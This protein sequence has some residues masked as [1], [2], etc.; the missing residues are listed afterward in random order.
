MRQFVMHRLNPKL[1]VLPY[2]II[3]L[4][5]VVGPFLDVD[6]LKGSPEEFVFWAVVFNFPHI[7]SSFIVTIDKDYV[8]QV[9]VKSFGPVLFII[10]SSMVLYIGSLQSEFRV[11]F[12]YLIVG[13][14][15]IFTT[16]HVLSQQFGIS[17]LILKQRPVFFNVI[18][19]ISL[20]ASIL[21]Y[22]K[23]FLSKEYTIVVYFDYFLIGIFF[24]LLAFLAVD[25][26]KY[27]NRIGRFHYCLNIVMML[28]LIVFS[29]FEWVL[30]L[31]VVP[32]FVHD[33]SAFLIYI[34]HDQNKNQRIVTNYV[35]SI[36]PAKKVSFWV[37]TPLIGILVANFLEMIFLNYLLL[38]F[39]ICDFSHYYLESRMWKKGS[40]FRRN[41]LIG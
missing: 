31:L 24:L 41:V 11:V 21:L 39:M 12:G 20:I 15:A 9:K 17:C 40:V 30:A 4:F 7:V 33:I 23:L 8:G 2:I 36:L 37:I 35:Y 38:L 22:V 28:V 14:Y 10:A 27:N 34:N 5:G 19:A 3:P 25:Y 32:R 18:K 13:L 1:L 6:V 26:T 29:H 16:H